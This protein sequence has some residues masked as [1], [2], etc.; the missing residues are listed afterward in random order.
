V[1]LHARD[2]FLFVR[3]KQVSEVPHERVLRLVERQHILH[4]AARGEAQ[5]AL[6]V[7]MLLFEFLGVGS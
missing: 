7:L 2:E 1:A 4:E 6:W 3:G 5:G